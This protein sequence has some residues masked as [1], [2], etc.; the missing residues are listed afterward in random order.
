MLVTCK[1]T[2]L[3]GEQITALGG[4]VHQQVFDVT[5][6]GAYLVLGLTV[7]VASRVY[8]SGVYVEIEDDSGHV[9]SAPLFLFEIIDGRPSQYWVSRFWDDGSFAFW[10]PSF[11]NDCYHDRLSESVPDVRRDYESVRAQ[12]REEAGMLQVPQVY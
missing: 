5:E 3:S 7:Y 12:L 8:G 4:S 9:V 1:M 10:P 6:G 11:F 2:T